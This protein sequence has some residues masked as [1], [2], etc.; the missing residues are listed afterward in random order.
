MVTCTSSSY[1]QANVAP[2]A[3]VP[4]HTCVCA[5]LHGVTGMWVYVC[6]C[7]YTPCSRRVSDH[8]PLHTCVHPHSRHD[9]YPDTCSTHV[10]THTDTQAATSLPFSPPSPRRPGCW[11]AHPS[12]THTPHSHRRFSG[13]G[14]HGRQ[15]GG[16][17]L[18]DRQHLTPRPPP[19]GALCLCSCSCFLHPLTWGGSRKPREEGQAATGP[20]QEFH[21]P[22][23]P[24]P[25]LK[26]A[27]PAGESPTGFCSRC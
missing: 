8:L 7:A 1:T 24:D 27:H 10:H 5:C 6:V 3:H 20:N 17:G 9:P 2:C 13:E 11:K 21:T 23:G 26:P 25:V 22:S 18:P 4:S 15:R 19:A 14:V 12:A 16:A